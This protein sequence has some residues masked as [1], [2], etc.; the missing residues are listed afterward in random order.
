MP[1]PQFIYHIAEEAAWLNQ[2]DEPVYSV[3]TL[4]DEGF[5]HCSR[6][7]QLPATLNRFF[8]NRED[9]CILKIDTKLL[10]VPLIY[11]AADDGSG[12]FP[13]VFGSIRKSSITQVYNFPFDFLNQDPQ[14]EGEQAH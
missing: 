6:L 11:E 12:F 4:D 7:E 9:I 10:Q 3:D 8:E 14:K 13:H 2:S 1:A 5:I